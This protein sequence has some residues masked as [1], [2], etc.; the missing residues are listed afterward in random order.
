M[1]QS[2]TAI[3]IVA[4]PDRLA[5]AL[6]P[7]RRRLM[8]RLADGP[9]SATGLASALGEP[10]QKIN[11]H[12][13]ALEEAGFVELHEERRRGNCVE[14]VV[15]T[16]ARYFLLDPAIMGSSDVDPDT[17]RDR[18][19]AAYLLAL[20]ARTIRELAA[21]VGGARR[22][23]KRLATFSLQTEVALARPSDM[24]SFAA[25]VAAAIA[26]VVARHHDENATGARRFRLVL[27]SYPAPPDQSNEET[28]AD[29]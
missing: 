22:E 25:D 15:R 6:T 1:G 12:V 18:F 10:R 27:G 14:R 13:R 4:D 23:K 21:L 26:D 29:E 3:D 20:A 19:S 16:T 2:T 5:V 24:R 9:D 28:H 8:A 11:Y 17:F 7:V